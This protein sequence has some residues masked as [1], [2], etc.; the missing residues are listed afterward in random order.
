MSN[1]VVV[2]K[3]WGP[4]PPPLASSALEEHE[5]IKSSDFEWAGVCPAVGDCTPL[6]SQADV[7]KDAQFNDQCWPEG[8]AS[9][10]YAYRLVS[11]TLSSLLTA[12]LRHSGH[13]AGYND[14]LRVELPIPNAQSTLKL[15]YVVSSMVRRGQ[16]TTIFDAA[17]LG[18]DVF[19]FRPRQAQ[20]QAL[21]KKVYDIITQQKRAKPAE[22]G[23]RDSHVD[24]C[25]ANRHADGCGAIIFQDGST[26]AMA[27]RWHTKVSIVPESE[28]VSEP[29]TK[30][31]RHGVARGN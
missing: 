14:R 13:K 2:M 23:G 20:N 19:H 7:G 12:Y 24:R 6:L 16:P 3:V 31:A 8:A 5:P 26:K 22:G 4:P 27:L 10:A 1:C 11:E 29:V 28:S 21:W 25:V 15:S 17:Q 18:E 30:R 9:S